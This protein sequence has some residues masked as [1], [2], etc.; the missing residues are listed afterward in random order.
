MLDEYYITPIHIKEYIFCPSILY[1]KYV[2]K[3]VEPITEMMRDGKEGYERDRMG[4]KRRESI[5]GDKR[6]KA[7]KIIFSR[8]LK[9]EKYRI[10]GIV[11]CIYWIN[12]KMNI[13]E[14]KYSKA[15]KPYPDH[16][17]Q[18]AAYALMA[19]EEFKQPVYKIIIYY[20]Y[21]KLWYERR[22]TNQLRRYVIKI[23]EDIR[24]ILDGDEIPTP[25]LSR[26]C[27]S[28]WYSRICHPRY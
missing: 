20:K 21:S 24:K 7:D 1:N 19:E 18:A 25:K 14:I 3:I 5:L 11:D 9:S 2:M 12:N 15:K 6:I 23:V 10:A 28:C 26:K 8:W 27:M 16:I 22:F 13:L 17:Y 4:L